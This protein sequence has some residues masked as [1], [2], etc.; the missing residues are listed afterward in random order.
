MRTVNASEIQS[1]NPT[2]IDVREYPEFA[3]GFIRGAQLVPLSEVAGHASA[4]S[5]D[6]PLVM[7]CKSGRRAT[8]AAEKLETIGF[9][10]VSVLNGGV[11][12]WRE[13]GLTLHTAAHR[14]W[15]LERQVRVAAGTLVVTFSVLGLVISP[16][17]LAGA[18]FV[19]A[20]LVFAGVSNTC[21]M[22]SLLGKMPWNREVPQ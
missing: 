19:G 2:L 12:A 11:D 4:W 3:A 22:G 13:Q 14:P 15:A 18:A 6:A 8:L 21:M 9:S 7:I 20:G 5:K 1:G 10:N 17:F 16:K